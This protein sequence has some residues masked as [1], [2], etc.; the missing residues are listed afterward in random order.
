MSRLFSSFSFLNS[1]ESNRAF[2]C[3]ESTGTLFEDRDVTTFVRRKVWA[4]RPWRWRLQMLHVRVSSH[5]ISLRRVFATPIMKVE[6]DSIPPSG[7]T[8]RERRSRFSYRFSPTRICPG[9]AFSLEI[10]WLFGASDIF[11]LHRNYDVLP[12]V[13]KREKHEIYYFSAVPDVLFMRPVWFPESFLKS[14]KLTSLSANIARSYFCI[15]S[16]VKH[17]KNLYATYNDSARTLVLGY[18]IPV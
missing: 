5:E 15:A 3:S 4:A 14:S 11:V 1:P 8:V 18:A 13:E 6:N 10:Y 17:E 12:L 9:A 7:K 2:D 16:R